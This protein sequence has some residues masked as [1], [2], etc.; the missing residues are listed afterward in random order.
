MVILFTLL[1]GGILFLLQRIL[2]ARWWSRGVAVKLSFDKEL[3]RAGDQVKLL[4]MVETKNGLPLSSLKVK[5]QCS[6][7]LEFSDGQNGNVTDKY[8]RN[9]LFSVMPYQRIT[10]THKITCPKR[11]YYGIDGINLVGADL[12]FSEEMV[13]DRTSDA[14]VYV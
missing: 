14:T 5:F 13:A 2:Y 6:R 4:E 10:R 7:Y 3:V 12:F 1:I 8:Y 9:D 11:G